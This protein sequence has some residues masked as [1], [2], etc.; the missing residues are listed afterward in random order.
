MAG[1]GY[2]VCVIRVKRDD[3]VFTAP[4]P[5]KAEMPQ[6]FS[7]CYDDPRRDIR[8]V[9]CFDRCVHLCCY[10]GW[11][12]IDNPPPD[13]T[14]VAPAPTYEVY[15]LDPLYCICHG[16]QHDPMALVKDVNPK[17]GATYVRA[18][19]VHGPASRALPVGPVKAERDVLVDGMPGP[20][21]YDYC[22]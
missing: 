7:R 17:N 19:R 3:A 16:S 18:R 21:W 22:G 4:A 8:I 15:G 9:L 6:G 5:G 12:V 13:R 10:P 20:R 11:H 14:C 2:P 1:S